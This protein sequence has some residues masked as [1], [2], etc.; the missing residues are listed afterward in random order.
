MEKQLI[1]AHGKGIALE[2]GG[3]AAA[4][5]V[6]H[7]LA[8]AHALVAFDTED[9]DADTVARPALGRVQDVGGYASHV[10]LLLWSWHRWA[11]RLKDRA[12][13]VVPTG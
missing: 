3:I 6:G 5:V 4:I 8:D 10:S 9:L 13:A 11:A 2:D 12:G 1:F 7:R